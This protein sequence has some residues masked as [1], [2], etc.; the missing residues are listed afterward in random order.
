MNTIAA[1]LLFIAAFLLVWGVIYIAM[2][3]ANRSKRVASRLFGASL[4]KMTPLRD[5]IARSREKS[6]WAAY[7]PA[8]LLTAAGLI[9]ALVTGDQ[10]LDLAEAFR[11]STPAVVK[12]DHGVHDWMQTHRSHPATV[13]F[14]AFTVLG[15]PP[16]MGGIVLLV[17]AVLF[18]RHRPRW[19][20]YLLLTAGGG[21]ALNQDLK[22]YF[23]RQRPD[24]TVAMRQASGFSFPSGHSMGSVVVF[25]ALAYL[26]WRTITN[27]KL[28]S[29]AFAF[30]L[31]CV[32]AIALSRVY[33]G[34]HWTTDI[35]AGISAGTLWVVTTT[36]AYEAFRRIHRLREGRPEVAE[37]ELKIEN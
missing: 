17:A 9:I 34:V 30:S 6:T 15:S 21:A 28:R 31:C 10:F 20:G 35:F 32:L 16:V 7:L 11:H 25:G 8:A 3:L 33:L 27:W 4:M 29:A 24:L 13:L 12:V 14:T 22:Y 19:A 5:A 2:P 36:C 37:T 26:A 23:A 18:L 1:F